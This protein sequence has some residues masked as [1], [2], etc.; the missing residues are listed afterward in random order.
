MTTLNSSLSILMLKGVTFFLISVQ[1]QILSSYSYKKFMQ[2][3]L[4]K[5]EA[6]TQLVGSGI[7]Y[8]FNNF[9]SKQ[10]LKGAHEK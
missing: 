5:H 8:R 9:K 7:T 3:Q 1:L 10:V 2:S 4:E 6:Q